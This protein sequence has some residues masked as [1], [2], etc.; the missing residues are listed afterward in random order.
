LCALAALFLLNMH[1]ES[2]KEYLYNNGVIRSNMRLDGNFFNNL[3]QPVI[4]KTN[5][6]GYIWDSSGFW[7]Q[8]P[9]NILDPGNSFGL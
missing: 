4:G 7:L 1:H 2:T 8:H 5:I 9:W 3:G 6:F